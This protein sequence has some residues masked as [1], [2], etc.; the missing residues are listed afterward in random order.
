MKLF[1]KMYD[2]VMVWSQH[3]LAPYFLAGM[4]FIESIFWPIPVDVMLAPMALKNKQRAWFF[5]GLATVFSVLGAA[6][7]YA[8]GYWA[9]DVIVAPVIETFNYGHKFEVVKE[10]FNNWGIWIVFIAGFSPMPYK[11]ITISAGVLSMSFFPFMIISLISRGMRFSMVTGLML[12]GG[13]KMEKKLKQYI[14][15]LGWLTIVTAVA[16]YFIL[17]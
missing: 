3:R 6:V 14:D 2:Q 12:W 11:V 8:L 5:A 16:A 9:F 17:R 13:D 15:I 7:G 10:W 1:S 4:S